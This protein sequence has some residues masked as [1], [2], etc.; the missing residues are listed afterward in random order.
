MTLDDTR[1]NDNSELIGLGGVV[2]EAT[3]SAGGGLRAALADVDPG[4]LDLIGTE[5]RPRAVVVAGA[6]GS[7]AAGDILA[8]C[9]GRGSSV[10]IVTTGGPSLPGWVGPLDLVI[11]LSASGASAET[12]A[13]A[14]EAA[15]R[16]T[17][18][19]AIGFSG[20]LI[21]QVSRQ[22]AA[23]IKLQPPTTPLLARTLTW[24]MSVPLLLLAERLGLVDTAEA[25]L[26]HAADVL[27]EVSVA[28]GPTLPLGEN[29]A[30]ELAVVMAESLSLVWG[31]PEV[32]AA[33]AR[34]AARQFAENAGIPV[35]AGSL[36]E[37]ARTHARVLA[38]EWG[39]DDDIFRDRVDDPDAPRPRLLLV[40]DERVDPLSSQLLNALRR[41]AEN[42]DVPVH[43]IDA[44]Q[45]HPLVRFARTSQLFDLASVYAAVALGLDPAQTARGLHPDLGAKG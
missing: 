7:S 8:A 38:G 23:V 17:R 41:V 22:R 21:D 12:L 2:L 19:V 39:A 5:G 3:A 20:P 26:T 29:F 25:S 10:P 44:G 30:K 42:S 33:V 32:P 40:R 31:T 14:N 11:T 36:P 37:V 1:L 15:R 18:L 9:A 27:D 45:G 13:L 6:G 24:R 4:V 16:G 43:M 35:L 28:N 34:R